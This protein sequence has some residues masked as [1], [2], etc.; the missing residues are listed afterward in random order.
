VRILEISE[1]WEG[2]NTQHTPSENMHINQREN[3]RDD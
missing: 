2:I 3:K 1:T